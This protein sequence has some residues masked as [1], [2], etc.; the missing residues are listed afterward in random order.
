MRAKHERT[1]G[2]KL[3]GTKSKPKSEPAQPKPISTAKSSGK[4][5]SPIKN[6]IRK[7]K[8]KAKP[9]PPNT[10]AQYSAKPEKFKQTWGR[11]I[12]TVAKM[13]SEKLTLTEAS[14]AIGIDSRTVKRWGGSALRKRPNGT[15]AVKPGDNL[16]RMLLIPTPEGTREIGVRGSKQARVLAEYWNAL[17]RYLQ[18]GDATKLR[19]FEGK[20]IRDASDLTIPFSVDLKAL[21]RLGAAG[22]LS[23]ES[24]YA[25]SA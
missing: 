3:A 21:N 14:R 6:S 12:S 2:G 22:V 7:L 13:R 10:E 23:F 11:V 8:P 9:K 17:H 19:S 25:R 16:L 24:I 1:F 4:K 5:T 15:F 20:Y 18:T